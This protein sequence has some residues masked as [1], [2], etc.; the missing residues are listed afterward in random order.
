MPVK[1]ALRIA[2]SQGLDLVEIAPN[3]APPVCGIVNLGKYLYE[4]KSK[5]KEMKKKQHTTQ[6]REIRFSMNISENDYQVKMNKI[7]EFL[8]QKDRVRV[9]LRL[10]GREILHKNLAMDIIKRVISDSKDIA[11]PEGPPK[12][13]GEGR[14]TIQ[15]MLLPK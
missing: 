14:Q 8:A 10:R 3:A 5:E 2:R 7:K 1:E 11:V 6:M 13:F 9:G 15:I 4:L 12:T